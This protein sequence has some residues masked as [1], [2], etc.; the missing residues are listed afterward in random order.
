MVGSSQI[1][2]AAAFDAAGNRSVIKRRDYTISLLAAASRQSLRSVLRRGIRV[3]V[4]TPSPQRVELAVRI[5]RSQ[6]RR[7]R[8]ATLVAR[9]RKNNVSGTRTLRVKLRRAA[10]RRLKRQ[11]RVPVRVSLKAS[12]Q[13]AGPAKASRRILLRR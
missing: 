12:G 11:R 9:V 2:K 7:L 6:S 8:I 1:L 3:S 4:T 10:I 13:G 5:G